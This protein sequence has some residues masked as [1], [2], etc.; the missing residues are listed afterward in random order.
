MAMAIFNAMSKDKKA[1][2]AG[3]Q[4]SVSSGAAQNAQLAVQKYGAKLD[5]HSS[6]QITIDD[7]EK[8]SL[9]ITMTKSHKMMLRSVYDSD[10]IITLA[11]YAGENEDVSDPFGGSIEIY[12]KTAQMIYEYLKKGMKRLECTFAEKD[13]T[14]RIA[15]LE[16]QCF[17][18]AWSLNL[19]ER[20]INQKRIIVIKDSEGLQGYCI[21]MIAADEGEILRIAID[22]NM[23]GRGYGKKLICAAINEMEALGCRSAFLE[24]RATN[25]A[26]ISLY[27]AVGFNNIGIRRG[28]YTD[29]NEDANLY[30]LEIK[31]R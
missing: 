6:R 10:K 23:R 28:Y 3:I 29:N 11:E 25:S 2:S 27:E 26:A 4:V 12:E 8:Y 9:I 21:F 7:L 24:V 14:Q 19:I 20:E 31:E 18:D 16:K 30:R 17:P 22:E 13:D 1:D 15:E 5:G